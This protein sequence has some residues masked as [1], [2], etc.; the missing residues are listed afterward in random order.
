MR[1]LACICAVLVPLAA[2]AEDPLETGRMLYT[3]YCE[4]CHG[5]DGAGG[6]G[7]DIRGLGLQTVHY[8]LEGTEQMPAFDFFTETEV[9]AIAAYLKRLESD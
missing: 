1:A 2:Q 4:S 3:D 7:E 6:A 9:E 5:A 8:A